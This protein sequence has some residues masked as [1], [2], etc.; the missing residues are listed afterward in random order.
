MKEVPRVALYGN[1]NEN[2]DYTN[3]TTHN[4]NCYLIFASDF[5]EDCY[6]GI[7]N[8]SKHSMDCLESRE[9]ENAYECVNCLHSYE[10]F[11]SIDVEHCNHS[12]FLINCTNC[13]HCF[14]SHNL[15]NKRYYFLNEPCTPAEYEQKIKQMSIAEA[16]KAFLEVKGKAIYRNLKITNSENCIGNY[17]E[18]SKDCK[19]CF[20]TLQGNNCSYVFFGS[21]QLNDCWDT[22]GASIN[23]SKCYQAQI[24]LEN[25]HSIIGC[26]FCNTIQFSYYL[27]SCINCSH[28]FGC[29]GLRNKQYC[30]LN[31]QYTKEDYEKLVAN[32]IEQMKKS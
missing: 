25:C 10:L 1:N 13:E 23:A 29:V 19:Y 5:N 31:Q 26:N 32:I 21:Q 7:F 22:V 4:K 14:L 28:C 15:H 3:D 11:Y 20:D 18:H 6:Y 12:A 24:C 30:I 9:V 27:D 2:A 8:D 16:K 17:I